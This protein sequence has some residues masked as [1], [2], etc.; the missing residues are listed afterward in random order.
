MDVW[1]DSKLLNEME[2][3]WYKSQI[4]SLNYVAM[5]TRYD[6]AHA[7]SR[8]S[9]CASKPTRASHT[10]LVRVFKYLMNT[11]NHTLTG[12][13][14]TR[15]RLDMYCDSDHAGDKPHTMQSHTRSMI[16]LHDTP[17]QWVSKKRIDGTA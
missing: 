15:D 12:K 1:S 11:P 7:V 14:V 5:T 3:S 9:L 2:A 17:I 8:L 16:L 10:A 4:G 13:V 6:V